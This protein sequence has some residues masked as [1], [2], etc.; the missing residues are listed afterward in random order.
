VVAVLGSMSRRAWLAL[1]AGWLM[2]IVTA[3]VW[4]ELSTERTMLVSR[5]NQ[6]TLGGEPVDVRSLRSYAG[7]GWIVVRSSPG[8]YYVLERPRL[9]LPW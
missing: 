2:G 1:L 9:R 4:P 3:V 7:D 5:P 8:Y 6:E